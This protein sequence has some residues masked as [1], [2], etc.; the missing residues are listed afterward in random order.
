MPLRRPLSTAFRL[1]LVEAADSPFLPTIERAAEQAGLP[2]ERRDPA[3]AA[4]MAAESDERT[5]LAVGPS[6][7]DAPQVAHRVR[8]TAPDPPLVLFL[9]PGL[10]ESPT[11]TVEARSL[12][13]A[14]RAESIPVGDVEEIAVRLRDL[15]QRTARLRRHQAAVSQI[16]RQISDLSVRGDEQGDVAAGA[17]LADYYLTA[18]LAQASD[19]IVSTDVEGSIVTWNTGAEHLFGFTAERAIGRH[20][21]FLQ[22]DASPPRGDTASLDELLKRVLRGQLPEQA[23]VVCARADGSSVEAS[24]SLAPIR[25]TTG[26][27]L[28]VTVI[29]RDV[30][31][32]R[33]VEFALREANRQK[34]EFLATV[35][36]ELRTPLTAIIGYTD[37]LL[38]GIAGP[39]PDRTSGYVGQVRAAGDRLLSLVN[40]LLDYSRLEAMTEP[41]TFETVDLLDA[42]TRA[43]ELTRADAAVKQLEMRA[44]VP[45]RRVMVRAD[46]EKLRRILSNYLSN[47][48]KFTRPG[49]QILVRVAADPEA[50]DMARVS[51]VDSGIGLAEDQLGRIWD[52]FY[53]VDSSL[54]REHG[55]MGLGL[56]I[57]RH[58]T[59]LH[60]GRVGVESRGLGQGSTFWIALPLAQPSTRGAEERVARG[61]P[62]VGPGRNLAVGT[63]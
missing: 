10:S 39:L 5:L 60:G 37:L 54:T 47:A 41:I 12:A 7:P 15:F 18:V 11:A 22:Q 45:E 42:V 52:R 57:V 43:V 29:A 55:G 34:D 23:D 51:V 13:A 14:H 2:V 32:R 33:R 3:D 36:H 21:G 25:D 40:A 4:A 9:S 56:A 8:A 6:V 35:S 17:V 53:Q 50:I 24:V 63:R 62:S 19:A 31:E 49:G 30:S 27:L 61:G 20:I 48:I 44:A 1:C 16:A 38:R 58:L 46:E 28:G 59:E 26:T